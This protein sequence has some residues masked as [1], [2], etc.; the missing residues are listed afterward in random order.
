MNSTD[1]L[2]KEIETLKKDLK[3]TQ[4]ML[5]NSSNPDEVFTKKASD[6]ISKKDEK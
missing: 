3:K 6:E 5:E 1:K 4:D 2:R